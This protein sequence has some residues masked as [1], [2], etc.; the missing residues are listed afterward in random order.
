MT[1]AQQFDARLDAR[2]LIGS[3]G[4][5][6]AKHYVIVQMDSGIKTRQAYWLQV[7]KELKTLRPTDGVIR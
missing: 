6:G 1:E 5:D 2:K 3:R 4:F 7:W